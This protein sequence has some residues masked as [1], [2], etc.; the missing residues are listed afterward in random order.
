[1]AKWVHLSTGVPSPEAFG[2][3]AGQGTPLIINESTGQPYYLSSSNIVTATAGGG[4]GG[5]GTV[6]NVALT[7]PAGFS[8]S[9]SPIT[10]SGTLALT[11]TLS[12]YVKGTGSGFTAVASIPS[13]DI[14]GL[15][16]LATQS[17]TFSGTSSGTNTGDQ[18]SVSGNAGTATAL[19]TP[20]TIS[21]TGK[22]TAT[23]GPFDGSGN[24]ALNI[25][26]V[27]LVA[28]DIP[29]IAQSQV[30]N[31]PADLAAK[32]P[33]D[34]QLTDLSGLVYA[35]NS[36]KVVRVNAGETGFELAIASGGSDPWTYIK[37]AADF[38]T[39]LATFSDI[40]GMTFTPAAN[41]DY[42]V[43]WCLMG[44]TATTTVGARPGVSYGTGYQYGVVDLYTPSS[45]TAETQVHGSMTT[46]AGT[47]QA[48]VGGLPIINRTYG[49]R[50]YASFRSDAAP[51]A[52]KLQLA[53]ETGGTTV[54]VRAGSFLKYRIIP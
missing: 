24:L 41:T 19:Q 49:H 54:T 35:G 16:T 3:T 17:G 31:L 29:T 39:S 20:R 18:T 51:T 47:V 37:L 46:V 26:A 27:T 12:G 30:T 52:F 9:G 10:G 42:E 44:Q 45:G 6:T 11:T 5:S 36:L 7:A 48:A 53:S 2:T 38:P 15:G 23:G 22:A 50:G 34:T 14:S 4:S 13:T 40:T 32:Q 8:V 43:E 28:G 21:I 33:L 25:T 1:M